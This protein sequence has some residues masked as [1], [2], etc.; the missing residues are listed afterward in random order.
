MNLNMIVSVRFT[1]YACILV[2]VC[3]LV[4][5]AVYGLRAEDSSTTLDAETVDAP[6]DVAVARFMAGMTKVD[7]T[8]D[9]NAQ[10]VPLQGYFDRHRKPAVSVHDPL[11][12]RALV[13]EDPSGNRIAVVGVD[14]C[15]VHS[16]VRDRVVDRLSPYGFGEHN[17]L[18]AATHTHSG[19]GAFDSRFL[20]D[21]IFS[22]FNPRMLDQAV[23]G[24]STAVLQA[25]QAM[26]QVEVEI[27]ST[28]LKGMNRSRRDPAF[29]FDVGGTGEK[30]EF[31]PEKYP[32]DRTLTVIRFVNMD[33]EPIGLLYN[34]SS[35]PT[36][37]SPKNMALSADWPGVAAE[38]IE[39]HLGQGAVVMFVNGSLGDAA[40]TPDW[41]ELEIEWKN[42]HEYG[43]QMA[44]HVISLLDSLKPMERKD[45]KARTQR[46]EF[47]KLVLR[48]LG[49]MR[50]PKCISK[51]GYKRPDQPIQA[52]RLGD[53]I[54]LAVPGEPTTLV[55][56]E[57]KS[58]CRKDFHCMI[59]AP[60]NG[61]LAY[62]TMPEEYEEGG[63][64][65]D[66]TLFGPK[67]ASWIRQSMSR[68]LAHV[69]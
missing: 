44:D 14:L 50:L 29:D 43:D 36:I 42:V 16:E 49:R 30:I 60:S 20:A 12:A 51:A 5:P 34:F 13:V 17:L 7:I 48:G 22:K 55:G 6:R 56:N 61:Y 18:I 25:E 32:T 33:S 69:Q 57:L 41:D 23:F 54:F 9:V 24:I 40:P 21:K 59:A 66:S 15:Y 63:Y 67:S 35:H 19:F 65:S 28:Q 4:L 26:T 52:M 58:L 45:V 1:R 11:Y 10:P 53:A 37:L 2:L 64:A 3:M 46:R 31:D 62:F 8:T 39:K 47:T 38:K 68:A 27:G